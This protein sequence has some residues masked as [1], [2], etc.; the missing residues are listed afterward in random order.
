VFWVDTGQRASQHWRSS[1]AAKAGVGRLFRDF[2]LAAFR[3]KPADLSSLISLNRH[4]RR[5][6]L[7]LTRSKLK[8][9]EFLYP[10]RIHASPHLSTRQYAGLWIVGFFSW[11][12]TLPTMVPI[13]YVAPKLLIY[14]RTKNLRAAQLLLGPSKLESTVRFL[15]IE[16]DDALEMAEQTEA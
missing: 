12:W 4:A 3:K 15:G 2:P 13:R 5:Y 9:E 6:Q 7:G 16:V 10:S 14:R 8:A 11:D 1:Q